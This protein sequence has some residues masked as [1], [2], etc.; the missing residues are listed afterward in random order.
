MQRIQLDHFFFFCFVFKI[1]N[2]LLRISIQFKVEKKIINDR[3]K[4]RKSQIETI[5]RTH[6]VI[7]LGFSDKNS[8]LKIKSSDIQKI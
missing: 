2:T 1:E 6:S 8:N 7:D 4:G 3:V 5:Y